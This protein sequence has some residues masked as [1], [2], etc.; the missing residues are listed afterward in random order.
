VLVNAGQDRVAR[1]VAYVSKARNDFSV[2]QRSDLI[3]H[4]D[5][6][7]LELTTSDGPPLLLVNLYNDENNTA[8][9][10]MD[11]INFPDMPTLITGDFNTRHDLWSSTKKF[12]SNS[13]KAEQ[14]LEWFT[15]SGFSLLNRK[16]EVTYFRRS[17]QSVL[18]L[19]WANR[20]LL[21]SGLLSNWRVR[22]D[23]VFG[24]DHVP[25]SWEVHHS[26]NDVLLPLQ[27]PFVF[28]EDSRDPWQKEFLACMSES[29]PRAFLPLE[30]ISKEQLA[31]A[32]EALMSSLTKASE[33]TTKRAH[34][35]PKSSAW[36]TKKVSDALTDMR[37]AHKALARHNTHWGQSHVYK[38]DL[39]IYIDHCKILSK[40]IRKAK[41]DWAMDFAAKI[42]TKDVWKLTN[43]YKGSRRH[44]S[45][46]LVHPDGRKAVTPEDKCNLL[47][48]TFFSS[49]PPLNHSETAA[50]THAPHPSTREFIDI[51]RDEVDRALRSTSNTLA[52][53]P[54]SVS[55]R[56]LK[57]AW[58][59]ASEE[60]HFVLKWSL[61]LGV[62]NQQW[63]SAITV[64]LT[65]PNKPSYSN[66]RAYRPIQLLECLGK[67]LEKIVA[68]RFTFDIGK[69]ELVP[70]EQFG[71]RSAASCIDAG[72]LLVHDIELAWKNGKVALFL[73]IDIKGF[74]DNINHRRMIKVLWEAG[75]P[76][77][78]VRWVESFLS[79]R[80][81]S[82]RLDD[83]TSP[84]SPIDIG[85][86][87]GS[88][89]S[90]VLSVL[91]SAALIITVRDHGFLVTP[92]GIPTSP[93]SF[94]DDLGLLA[95]ADTLEDNVD[96]LRKGLLVVSR[97]LRSIGMSID[98]S[99]LE[100]QH[101]SRRRKDNSSPTLRITLYGEEI[102][103]TPA[104]TMR[105]LGIY[106]DHKLTFHDHVRIMANRTVEQA[107]FYSSLL[108][109]CP[110]LTLG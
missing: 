29:F 106:L 71:G 18:D 65:K 67:L 8:V 108:P 97:K 54:S 58:A 22:E 90:P 9:S 79:N 107:Q 104:A 23:L 87:Q 78:E 88:P 73:A 60:I 30:D 81:A 42:E 96:T 101:F 76:L 94:V 59:V 35:H 45:P 38:A 74:F 75:F 49:P 31:D 82:I 89:C 44:H 21:Q 56:A 24:S 13:P 109:Y 100:I 105:W 66:P 85:S 53:G 15:H 10:L 55:Y 46:P 93:K 72:L 27:T 25:L 19:S 39:A 102:T 57:W 61:H 6:L 12:V 92:I 20:K 11:N 48:E 95:M 69:Y 2:V 52:P 16:G 91:Y 70:F 28:K 33:T 3:E 98:V 34:F 43:W 41:R 62:H 14:M 63:K 26:P 4:P 47:K 83:Y 110:T 36:F 32:T 103:I 40:L 5:V 1:V 37:E 50:N 51:T 84:M 99:K 68:K 77:P 17:T 80:C 7:I 86:P 64:V